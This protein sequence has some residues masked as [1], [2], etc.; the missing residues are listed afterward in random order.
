MKTKITEK[1]LHPHLKKRMQ[2]RGITTEEIETTL[3]YGKNA[4]DARPGT[5]GKTHVFTFNNDWEG[6]YFKEKEVT[7]YYKKVQ[8]K[9]ILLTALVRYDEDFQ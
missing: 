1:D 6:E 8:K 3:N 5:E 9:I 2:E 4:K 7:V